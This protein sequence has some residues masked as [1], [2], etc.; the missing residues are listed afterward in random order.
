MHSAGVTNDEWNSID[1]PNRDPTSDES[2]GPAPMI[3]SHGEV[4]SF[5]SKDCV[6]PAEI[7]WASNI[8]MRQCPDPLSAYSDCLMFH[9]TSCSAFTV[10]QGS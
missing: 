3:R 2:V 7:L 5:V 10:C 9:D 4:S 8:V 1:G 6:L